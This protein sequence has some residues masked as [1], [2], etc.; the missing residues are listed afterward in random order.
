MAKNNKSTK[1]IKQGGDGM[2]GV[3]YFLGVIGAA[4]YFVQLS[5]GV[6]GFILALLKALVWPAFVVYEVLGILNI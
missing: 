1:V 4:I 2:F 5:A 6:G 3:T